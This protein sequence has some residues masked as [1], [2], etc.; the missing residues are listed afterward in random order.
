MRV[1]S[2]HFGSLQGTGQTITTWATQLLALIIL[3]A[4]L[5]FLLGGV[6][7]PERAP[8]PARKKRLRSWAQ[9]ARNRLHVSVPER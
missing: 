3:L 8:L 2:G 1:T 6:V 5:G 7:T 4:S 9:A